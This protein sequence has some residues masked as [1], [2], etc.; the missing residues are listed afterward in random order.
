MKRKPK[1]C[2]IPEDDVTPGALPQEEVQE[3]EIEMEKLQKPTKTEQ[4]ESLVNLF[5]EGMLTSEEFTTAKAK[6]IGI[7]ISFFH[8]AL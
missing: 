1:N 5:R 3:N 8:L 4:L 7:I 2:E 6:F